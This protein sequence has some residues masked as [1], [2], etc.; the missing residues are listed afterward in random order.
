MSVAEIFDFV[1]LFEDVVAQKNHTSHKGGKGVR[2]DV[3]GCVATFC[4]L[5]RGPGAVGGQRN[6][7]GHPG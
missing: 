6:A 1:L 4:V 7:S 5:V 2:E 3:R